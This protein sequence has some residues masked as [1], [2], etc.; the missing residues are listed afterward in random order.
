[1][2]VDGRPE[3]SAQGALAPRRNGS[4]IGTGLTQIPGVCTKENRSLVG[5]GAGQNLP[6]CKSAF[7][8]TPLRMRSAILGISRRDVRA[9]YSG[10]TSSNARGRSDISSDRYY[11]AGDGAARH[12]YHRARRRSGSRKPNSTLA[13]LL[14]GRVAHEIRGIVGASTAFVLRYLR[15]GE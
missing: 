15:I 7:I 5:L 14:F 4:F 6:N 13:R 3:C 10:A 1:M 12:P 2:V 11:A 9:A 8:N